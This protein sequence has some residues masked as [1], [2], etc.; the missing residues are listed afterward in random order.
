MENTE[1][2]KQLKKIKALKA[3]N[4]IK[5][6]A[7]IEAI[8]DNLHDF[9]IDNA[10]DLDQINTDIIQD[11]I[12]RIIKQDDYTKEIYDLESFN[13][14]Y[15]DNMDDCFTTIESEVE[16]LEAG[17]ENEKDSINVQL[18]E[19]LE[20]SDQVNN[21]DSIDKKLKFVEK[22]SE[23]HDLEGLPVSKLCLI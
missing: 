2:K 17:I 3:L 22:C 21:Y 11:E 4:E 16:E 10:N 6:N 8:L 20:F 15:S 23:A 13:H 19:F 14:D 1:I 12:K 9:C 5:I 18:R 7:V